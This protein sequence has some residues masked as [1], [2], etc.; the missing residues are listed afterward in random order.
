MQTL[1]SHAS[2]AFRS[3]GLIRSSW[4]DRDAARCPM[5]TATQTGRKML[6]LGPPF[7][8][9]F[10]VFPALL[11]FQES[12]PV[13]CYERRSDGGGGAAKSQRCKDGPGWIAMQRSIDVWAPLDNIRNGY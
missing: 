8:D 13:L 12:R 3:V 1:N 5:S 6:P 11:R 9:R 4:S 2:A 7:G 10:F